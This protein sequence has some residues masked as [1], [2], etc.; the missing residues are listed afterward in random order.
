M[1]ISETLHLNDT[2]VPVTNREPKDLGTMEH[3]T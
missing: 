2:R 3:F 1:R